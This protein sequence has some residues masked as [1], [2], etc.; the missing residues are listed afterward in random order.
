MAKIKEETHLDEVLRVSDREILD[1]IANTIHSPQCREE[2]ATQLEHLLW[3]EQSREVREFYLGLLVRFLFSAL[4]DADRLSAAGHNVIMGSCIGRGEQWNSLIERIE[5]HIAE[6][7]QNNWVDSIRSE[8]SLACREFASRE[9]G[10]YLLTVPTGGAKTL[11]S[12]RFGVHHAARHQMDR[13]V[14][15][16]P[17]T[18][19]IDQNAAVARSMLEETTSENGSPIVLE[20]HSNLDPGKRNMAM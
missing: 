2:L 5:R 16:I 11:A 8:V 13:I 7:K 12:L 19:I 20:H 15:V 17:Y 14:Y 10:L 4:I 9:K 1:K 3:N 6:I 18:S